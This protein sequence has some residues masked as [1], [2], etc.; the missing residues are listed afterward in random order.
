MLTSPSS[1]PSEGGL[2]VRAAQPQDGRVVRRPCRVEKLEGAHVCGHQP[3]SLRAWR[4][5]SM[6]RGYLAHKTWAWEQRRKARCTPV[7]G[8]QAVASFRSRVIAATRWPACPGGMLSTGARTFLA[9]RLTGR[10]S[11]STRRGNIR[12][13]RIGAQGTRR[14]R[15]PERVTSI[16]V[17]QAGNRWGSERRRSRS[18]SRSRGLG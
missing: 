13:R 18:A 9:E 4:P 10:R 3:H 8:G 5:R 15:S 1:S 16:Q 7:T 14:T 2:H 12:R 17:E 11:R 6:S